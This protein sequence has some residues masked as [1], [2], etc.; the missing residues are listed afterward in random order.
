MSADPFDRRDF[1]KRTGAL[2][3]GISVAAKAFSKANGK[4]SPGRVIGANDRINVALIGCGGR[5]QSD[6][7]AFAEYAEAHANS[8][9]IVAVCDV[10]EKRKREAAERHKAK[11]SVTIGTS[12]PSLTSMP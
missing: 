5:G 11:A 3:A 9:Q 4:V 2:G 7:R 6:A 1:L 10:Y 12:W 8:C